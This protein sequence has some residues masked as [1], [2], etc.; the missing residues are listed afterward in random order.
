MR[1]T[2]EIKNDCVHTQT[3]HCKDEIRGVIERVVCFVL[4]IQGY[5][6][7]KYLKL[8]S[9]GDMTAKEIQRF[10]SWCKRNS[11]EIRSE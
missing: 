10:R 2:I 11:I 3:A 8:I 5:N 6:G 4:N 9:K 7:S 1:N